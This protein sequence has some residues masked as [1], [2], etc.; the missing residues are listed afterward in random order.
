MGKRCI[1]CDED[2]KFAI[3]GTSDFYCE[4]CAK[5][6]FSDISVLVQVEEQAKKIK[7]LV[8]ENVPEDVQ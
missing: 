6:H 8:E 3:K 4:E 2:A 5:E 7:E 1:I